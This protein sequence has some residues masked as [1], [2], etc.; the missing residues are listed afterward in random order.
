MVEGN[1]SSIDRNSPGRTLACPVGFRSGW[2]L[3]DPESAYELEA[4]RRLCRWSRLASD[5]ESHQPRGDGTASP[6]TGAGRLDSLGRN[7][8][9][10]WGIGVFI[11]RVARAQRVG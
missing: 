5:R 7:E 9:L 8:F 3:V 11:D 6:L 4:P 2:H 1:R 10:V